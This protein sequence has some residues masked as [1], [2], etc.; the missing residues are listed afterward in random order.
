M[1][2]NVFLLKA[3]STIWYEYRD[4]AKQ[5]KNRAVMQQH[6]D[7]LFNYMENFTPFETMSHY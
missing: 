5:G 2:I 3:Q 4:S 6:I 7:F 1:Q